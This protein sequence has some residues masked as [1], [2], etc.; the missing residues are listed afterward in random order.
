[1]V[2]KK[3]NELINDIAYKSTFKSAQRPKN[4]KVQTAHTDPQIKH[5][6]KIFHDENDKIKEEN[7]NKVNK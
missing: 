2:Y 1:M 7:E 4:L 5:S 6:L 3:M